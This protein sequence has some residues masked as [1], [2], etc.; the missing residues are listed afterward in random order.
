LKVWL[1]LVAGIIAGI[2]SLAAAD[3]LNAVN[4]DRL[5]GCGSAGAQMALQASTKLRLAAIRIAEGASLQQAI[6]AVGYLAAKSSA[7][8]VSGPVS[9]A[10]IELLIAAHYCRTVQDPQMREFGAERRGRDV[11]MILAAPVVLPALGDAA[12]V[13]RRILDLVNE[14]RAMGRRCGSKYFAPAGALSLDAALTRAALEHSRDMASHGE[15]DHRGHDG[16]TPT[17]RVQRAGFANPRVVGENIAAGAMTPAEVTQGWLASPAHCENIM[18][19]RFT[20]IGI[21][22]AENLNSHSAIFWTQDFA[23][24]R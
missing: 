20:L 2:P 16:S 4:H 14:A 13:D 22:Y 9:D 6:A 23:A 19:E 11:W 17:L 21:A 15:F 3:S 12:A 5:Q 18:D 8:H 24:R 10:D 1:A 7:I